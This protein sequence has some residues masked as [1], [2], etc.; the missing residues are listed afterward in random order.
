MTA[1]QVN[2]L[3]R[4]SKETLDAVHDWLHSNG[5]AKHRIGYSPAK[6]WANV[7][8]SIDDAEALL[9]TKF[10][11]Y[12]HSD[13]TQFVRTLQ[14]SIPA[15]LHRYIDTIQ[16]TNSFLRA[17]RNHLDSI[18]VDNKEIITTKFQASNLA[19]TDTDGVVFAACGN[20]TRS[21]TPNC[22]RTL[23]GTLEYKIQSAAKNRVGITNYLGELNNRSD[24]QIFLSR[25]RKDIDAVKAAQSFKQISVAGGTLQQTPNNA[26]QLRA[27]NGLE[28]NLDIETVLGIS[29]PTPVTVYSTGGS[30][31]FIP[32][33]RTETNSNEPYLSWV[34][35]MSTIKD[36][37]LPFVISTSY[38]DDEQTMPEAYARRVCSE[39]A[40]LG[41]RGVS[42]LFSSGDNGVGVNGRC[43]TNDGK[44]TTQFLP[45]FP[46]SCPFVTA[47]GGTKIGNPND[48][49]QPEVAARDVFRS[50]AVFTSGAGFSNYFKKPWYQ[51]SKS[52]T[53]SHD[54]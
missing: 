25:Y 27:G 42:L 48:P 15:A 46:A 11:Q 44:N 53:S 34:Q 52:S 24:T 17:R 28:G 18:R 12:Q 51:T 36:A 33:L 3:V 45:S 21:I 22:L 47:I 43:K 13:G 54:C 38:G 7:K 4:P 50:G 19:S 23:Y 26:S 39:F 14:Y 31:P 40:H 49:V 6:D 1:E 30:P 29:Y 2:L 5:I 41:A 37:D 8:L 10:S 20:G 9:D 16:P 35:H 32:D